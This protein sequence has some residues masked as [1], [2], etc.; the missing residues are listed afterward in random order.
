[1]SMTSNKNLR[2]AIE[3]AKEENHDDIMTRHDG[4]MINHATYQPTNLP[5]LPT[6]NNT[7]PILS[8][9]FDDES[10][11]D[12]P[13]PVHPP[14]QEVPA[15]A[16]QLATMLFELHRDTWDAG[17]KVKPA[18]LESWA[19]DIDK[20]NRLDNRGWDEIEAVI[21]FVKAMK[22]NGT[23]FTWAHNIMSGAK[24]REKFPTLLVQANQA[25]HP[26]R[27]KPLRIDSQKTMLELED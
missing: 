23:G 24:L 13:E 14:K 7:S 12:D 1:M 27:D 25:K 26:V 8:D 17:Y 3:K 15:R 19:R 10:F 11:D 20:I 16:T 2:S 22:P 21:R 4:S 5:N 9:P 18:Q 6:N